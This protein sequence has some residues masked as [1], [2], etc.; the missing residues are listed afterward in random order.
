MH[1]QADDCNLTLST[2]TDP[3]HCGRCSFDNTTSL[4][5]CDCNTVACNPAN[6][7]RVGDRWVVGE[8]GAC[9]P[10]DMFCCF[11]VGDLWGPPWPLGVCHGRTGGRT[12]GRR[13]KDMG[14]VRHRSPARTCALYVC[15][16]RSCMCGVRCQ[17]I[18]RASWFTCQQYC[19]DH[20]DCS[21]ALAA[22]DG[23]IFLFYAVSTHSLGEGE[24]MCTLRVRV[25]AW[26]L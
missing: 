9:L 3:C 13:R 6:E 10:C 2:G 5:T 11:V 22:L 14:H 1:C 23:N 25:L 4:I 8:A 21:S 16:P 26:S 24:P 17:V 19:L 15:V 18:V 7:S 20:A 12:D